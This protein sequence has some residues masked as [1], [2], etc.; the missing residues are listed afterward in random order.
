MCECDGLVFCV[1]HTRP[2]PWFHVVLKPNLLL[3]RHTWEKCDLF[4]SSSFC[5][6]ERVW[7]KER[8]INDLCVCVRL[9]FLTLC[10]PSILHQTSS[11]CRVILLTVGGCIVKC[12]VNDNFVSCFLSLF[13][14]FGSSTISCIFQFA[15]LHQS[16]SF[17]TSRLCS[18]I[19]R[20]HSIV[21]VRVCKRRPDECN[22]FVRQNEN[23]WPGKWRWQIPFVT[24]N[25]R[26]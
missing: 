14:G 12:G 3:P 11:M 7:L 1:T 26:I 20:S 2:R 6:R 9:S 22:T 8:Q 18:F 24:V 17:F 5:R 13:F 25:R 4:S 15:E 19:T 21:F 23:Q 10:G 16:F